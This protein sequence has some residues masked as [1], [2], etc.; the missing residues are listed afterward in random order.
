MSICS[1]RMPIPFIEI[2]QYIT[3]GYYWG[4]FKRGSGREGDAS[5]IVLNKELKS[6]LHIRVN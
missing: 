6:K 5:T 1:G 4:Y 2:F 3:Y